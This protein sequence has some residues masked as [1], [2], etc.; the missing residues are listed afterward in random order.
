MCKCNRSL[1]RGFIYLTLTIMCH[2]LHRSPLMA[3][4]MVLLL[5]TAMMTLAALSMFMNAHTSQD[6]SSSIQQTEQGTKVS[7]TLRNR[8][9]SREIDAG[10]PQTKDEQ[11]SADDGSHGT[12]S[13]TTSTERPLFLTPNIDLLNILGQDNAVSSVSNLAFM[14]YM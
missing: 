1:Y 9:V 5:G 12:A 10:S 4:T 6:H 11:T 13:K 3:G 7:V 2:N 8:R 14:A